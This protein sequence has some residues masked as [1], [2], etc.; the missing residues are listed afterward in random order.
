MDT[1]ED[2]VIESAMDATVASIKRPRDYDKAPATERELR[3]LKKHWRV[4]GAKKGKLAL[5]RSWSL[6]RADRAKQ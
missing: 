6:T 5:S 4:E 1:S 2:G 3:R